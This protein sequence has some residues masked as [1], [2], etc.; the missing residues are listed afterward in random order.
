MRPVRQ[1]VAVWGLGLLL[2]AGGTTAAT[3]PDSCAGSADEAALL[4]CRRAQ[5]A[6]ATRRLKLAIEQLRQRYAGDEPERWRLL[7][8]AQQAWRQ[9]QRAEC[10]FRHQESSGGAAYPAYLL[11]CLTDLSERRLQDLQVILAQP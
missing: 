7:Q 9:Y 10:R 5:H 2:A 11:S 6:D 3:P 4:T 1:A 8:A